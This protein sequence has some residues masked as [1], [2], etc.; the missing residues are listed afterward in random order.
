MPHT[1]C[2]T[3]PNGLRCAFQYKKST[4]AH[5]AVTI[6]AGSRDELEHQQGLAHF[7]EHNLFKGTEKR[8]AYHVLSRLDDVGGELNAYTT[9]E[10]TIIHASF[11]KTDFRRA[12]EL[13]AD[14]VFKSTFPQK[15]LDKEKEVIN[16]TA[17]Q[18]AF[19]TILKISFSTEMPS[20]VIS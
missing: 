10:E 6:K 14:V 2:F 18:I 20:G 12:A 3:L 1:H 4:V 8:K 7:I 5:M 19:S 9:K 13:V 15:E 17:P 11:L 16:S